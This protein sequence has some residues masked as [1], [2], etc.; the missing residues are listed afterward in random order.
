MRSVILTFDVEDFI[1]PISI[2]ALEKIL[3]LLKKYSFKSIFFIT[4]HEA[5]KIGCSSSLVESLGEHEIGYHSSSHSVR[6][7]IPEFTDTESFST[8][9]ENSFEREISHINPVS[10]EIEGEGGIK[11]LKKLFSSKN[12]TSFRAP[13]LCWTP[14]HL[15]A[16]KKLGIKYDFSSGIYGKGISTEMIQ[17]FMDLKFFPYPYFIDGINRSLGKWGY[18]GSKFFFNILHRKITCL[19]C[20]EWEFAISGQWDYAYQTSNPRQICKTELLEEVDM[21]RRFFYFE[22]FL[23]FLKRLHDLNLVEVTTE[24]DKLNCEKIDS[25]EV[26]VLETY[27]KSMKWGVE[28]MN[29]RPKHL[30]SHFYHYFQ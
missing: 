26:D 24:I 11:I 23:K 10:G 22:M 9:V 20:H 16:M 7:I 17:S 6:P 14:P 13:G 1:N 19:N 4:G 2:K 28:H 29:H 21:E 18:H 15:E 27:R 12:I 30:L 3:F 25:E 8:A 5:E